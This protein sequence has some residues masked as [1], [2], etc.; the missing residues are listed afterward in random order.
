MDEA[1]L[2]SR[3]CTSRVNLPYPNP[4]SLG[5]PRSLTP[6]LLITSI[7]LRTS[8]WSRLATKSKK[9]RPIAC[10]VLMML[11]FEQYRMVQLMV[12]RSRKSA[13]RTDC[14]GSGSKC[15]GY[16]LF[17]AVGGEPGRP[18]MRW[19]GTGHGGIGLGSFHLCRLTI[20]QVAFH[21]NVD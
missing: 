11:S 3:P 16:V 18:A 6:Q 14:S 7:Q 10:V 4:P 2:E 20:S 5:C 15:S 21:R 13:V 17:S 9:L 19:V 12:K 8:S 1:Y